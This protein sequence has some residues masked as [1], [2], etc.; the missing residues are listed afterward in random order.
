M[1]KKCSNKNFIQNFSQSLRKLCLSYLPPSCTFFGQLIGHGILHTFKKLIKNIIWPVNTKGLTIRM[2][3][4]NLQIT[5]NT[6]NLV[7][8]SLF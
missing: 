3:K 8:I 4:S 5:D 1:K 6:K 7:F 2:N